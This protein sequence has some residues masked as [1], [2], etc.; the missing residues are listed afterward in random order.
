MSE[1]SRK[2]LY[3]GASMALLAAIIWAG[4]FLVSKGV[5][6]IIPPVSL[7]FYR[8]FTASIFII[9]F[10]AGTLKKE[11]PVIRK[12]LRL[13]LFAAL[14]GVAVFNTFI[15]IAGHY[16]SA[17]NMALIGTTSSPVF[18]IIISAIFLNVK[19]RLIRVF[20]LLFCIAGIL[21]LLSK[22]SWE[23]LTAFRF[24]VGDL[25]VLASALSFAIYNILVK[26]KPAG[27]S[28]VN[29]LKAIFWLGTLM[30]L[31]FFIAERSMMPPI[32]WSTDLLLIILYLG[33][34]T[35]VTSFL[36][37]NAAIHKLGS[38]RTALFGN[39][40]PIFASIEAI[41]ILG[42]SLTIF[43]FIAGGC[44]VIGLI[45]ANSRKANQS[46]PTIKQS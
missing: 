37:W 44:V 30:I 26:R 42:E 34:G 10:G 31:P 6:D 13:L 20:G 4:N 25:W 12:N 1:L 5:A 29:F 15:Y 18:V 11:V 24:A 22:G 17:I 45:L 21:V 40:I 19:I 35:S 27:L 3:I 36:L 46:Q 32:Q 39:L 7:A 14:T 43:H 28:S 9:P 8:W 16:T 41:W 23:T 38:V 2:Q 33:L